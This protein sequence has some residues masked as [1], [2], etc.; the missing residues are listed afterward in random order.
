MQHQSFRRSLSFVLLVVMSMMFMLAPSA[1]VAQRN[2]GG[3]TVPVT[4]TNGFTGSFTIQQFVTQ[5]QQLL[6]VGTLVGTIGGTAI[7]VTTIRL[8]VDLT[9]TTGS[10]EI[11]H[12]VLQGITL[13]LLG[14]QVT[15]SEV[16]LDIT[17]QAGAGNLLGNLLCAIA[18]LLDAGG[19]L[20]QL[21]QLLNQL[22][23][24]LLG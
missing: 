15:L 20:N 9:N 24:A 12:L 22:L 7:A 8:P 2:A 13:D 6:A 17:A 10:C 5:G 23:A 14:L 16:I 1:A 19:P 4:G 18:G 3:V 21:V 11:L